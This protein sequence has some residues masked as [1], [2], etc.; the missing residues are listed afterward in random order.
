MTAVK[1][2]NGDGLQLA[3]FAFTNAETAS[4]VTGRL[5]LLATIFTVINAA[6]HA[7]EPL[8]RFNRPA[9][10]VSDASK[11]RDQ[12]RCQHSEETESGDDGVRA[13]IVAVWGSVSLTENSAA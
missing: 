9:I 1:I 10:R 13:H 2:V 3:V 8:R 4:R 12:D 11:H 7:F 5:E 6:R